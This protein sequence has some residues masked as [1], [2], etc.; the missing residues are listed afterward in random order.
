MTK[1]KIR[2]FCSP[3][4]VLLALDW[5]DGNRRD[6]LGFAISRAPGFR[7]PDGTEEPESWLPNRIGFAGPEEGREFPSD[8]N[9]IQKFLPGHP[10][11]HREGCLVRHQQR[12]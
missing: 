3:T 5:P 8:T 6:F 7:R 12:Q 1:A 11:L 10:Q 9:P 4:L 2:P